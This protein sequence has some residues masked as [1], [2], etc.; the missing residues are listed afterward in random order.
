MNGRA[1]WHKRG[2]RLLVIFIYLAVLTLI[3]VPSFVRGDY[4][5]GILLVIRWIARIS[6][7]LLVGFFAVFFVGEGLGEGFPKPWNMSREENI[8]MFGSLLMVAGVL[9]AWK[10]ELIGAIIAISGYLIFCA[11][12]GHLYSSPF[13]AFPIISAL[14]LCNWILSKLTSI[15]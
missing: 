8:M 5:A 6:A 7:I 14:Y 2:K 12:D 15:P 9:A 4:M 11:T 1:K 13:V 10:W 3:A